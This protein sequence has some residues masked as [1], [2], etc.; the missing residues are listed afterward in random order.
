M[1]RFVFRFEGETTLSERQIWP[2]G[3]APKNPTPQDV[4]RAVRRTSAGR[5]Y[6]SAVHLASEWGIDHYIELE[7]DGVSVDF[8]ALHLA[9]RDEEGS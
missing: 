5:P 6:R 8:V 2:D 4:A 7:V 9:R 3:D 1:K